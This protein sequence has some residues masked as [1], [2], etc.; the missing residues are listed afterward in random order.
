MQLC[1]VI[2]NINYHLEV[3]IIMTALEKLRT[4]TSNYLH[5]CVGL[6][7]DI[8][9]IPPHLLK[10]KNPVFEFNKIIIDNTYK[11][12]SAYKINF[13]FYE[14]DGLEG[15]EN[16]QRTLEYIPKDVNTI[17]DAKRGD[18]GNTSQMY[19]SSIFDHFGFDA[20][21]VNPYMGYDSVQP[22]LGYKD[23]LIFILTL[24]SNES[25]SDFEKIKCKEGDY[26][27]QKVIQKAKQWNI[28]GNCGI[29]FGATN[30]TELKEN[31]ITFDNLTVLLPGVGAQ[32]GSLE[33]VVSIFNWSDKSHFI[34]NISRALIYCDNSSQFGVSVNKT[35]E[36]YNQ[37]VFE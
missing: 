37:K 31:I 20:V 16:L 5:I 29:V 3:L 14:K 33:E 9:K 10:K 21:T 34:I 1:S 24:T 19:A 27:Y 18:I 25:A 15:I 30:A 4:K 35:I 7:T 28:Y 12:T 13:A 23:K 6:D 36:D 26:I 32:G 22:F 8:K 17:A 2:D 11:A